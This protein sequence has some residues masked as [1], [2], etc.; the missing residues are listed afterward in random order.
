[1]RNPSVERFKELTF[2]A[3]WKSSLIKA[4]S[5]IGFRIFLPQFCV[6]II[7]TINGGCFF[8]V[9]KFYWSIVDLQWCNNFCYTTKWRSHTYTHICLF[10]HIN[11]HKI[12]GRVL[13]AIQQVLIGQ[14][15]HKPQCTYA[16]PKPL[17]PPSY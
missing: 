16:S 9:L 2:R 4:Q 15:F 10:S 14:S 11:Y 5:T 7:I 12:L 3:F 17:V 1:M 8:I 13:C 6:A